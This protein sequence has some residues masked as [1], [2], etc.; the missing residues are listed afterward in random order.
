MSATAPSPARGWAGPSPV[1]FDSEVCPCQEVCPT[2]GLCQST[3]SQDRVGRRTPDR[4]SGAP[5]QICMSR[6]LA[7]CCVAFTMRAGLWPSFLVVAR[8]C[9]ITTRARTTLSG[10]VSRLPSST[11]ISPRSV[12]HSRMSPIWPGRG[13]SRR[14]RLGEMR[15]VRRVRFVSWLMPT[16]FR[17]VSVTGWWTPSRNASCVTSASGVNARSTGR[18]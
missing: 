9:V 1:P 12:T 7:F 11:S 17:K 10:T 3:L 18:P 6:G 13:A 4:R 15:R 16:G 2:A 5:S 8:W 14:S